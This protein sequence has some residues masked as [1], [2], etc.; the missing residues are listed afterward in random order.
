MTEVCNRNNN[1]SH[2]NYSIMNTDLVLRTQEALDAITNGIV[3][4][5][6][7]MAVYGEEVYNAIVSML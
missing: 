2:L 5:Y 7:V 6:D 3:Q 1:Q 4:I